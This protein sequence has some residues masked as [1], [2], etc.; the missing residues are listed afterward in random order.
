M[1]EAPQTTRW[2]ELAARPQGVPR[3]EDF[4]LTEAP[5]PELQEGEVL[6]ANQALSV[7]PYMRGRMD[8]TKS[9]GEPFQLDQPLDGGAVGEVIA[10]R[11]AEV[12]VGQMVM[13]YLGWREFAVLSADQVQPIDTSV[14]PAA[15]YLG[16]LGMTGLTA[17]IGLTKI[18]EMKA[19]DAVFISGAAGAVGSIAG[20]IARQLGASWVIGSAGSAEKVAML[21]DLGFNAAFNYRDAPVHEQLGSALEKGG[22]EGVDVYFD[23]VGGDHLEAALSA[24]NGFGR[25]ALCGAISQYNRKPGEALQGPRNIV[26][27]VGKQLTL[28]GFLVSSYFEYEQ[29]YIRFMAP[30]LADGTIRAQET[31]VHGFENT[32]QAMIDLLAGGNTGKMVVELS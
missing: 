26:L 16:V 6:V 4:R 5:L 9:Y 27:A 18:A 1:S 23:N 17:Y 13:H 20:Q 3:L 22:I 12:E 7:D 15:A 11:S 10:S 28:R 19:G 24:M 21:Q 14:A 32:A 30:L 29:E 25:A 2:F 8:D 31:T